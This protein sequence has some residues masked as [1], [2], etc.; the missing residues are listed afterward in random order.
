[1]IFIIL[2]FGNVPASG[3]LCLATQNSHP[4]VSAVGESAAN[5]TLVPQRTVVVRFPEVSVV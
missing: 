1:M 4:I 3:H 2:V 5:F